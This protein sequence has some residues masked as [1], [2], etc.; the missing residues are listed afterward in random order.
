MP[1]DGDQRL[2][3]VGETVSE[4]QLPAELTVLPDVE[5]LVKAGEPPTVRAPGIVVTSEARAAANPSRL[6]EADVLVAAEIISPGTGT[7]DRRH[8]HR[9]HPQPS[10]HHPHP[11]RADHPV[12]NFTTQE[13]V[14]PVSAVSPGPQR[15]LRP[16]GANRS[17]GWLIGWAV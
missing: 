14:D 4:D 2:Q 12:N 11:G 3:N 13:A 10:R 6:E 16:G 1:C 15:R 5:V 8:R 7:T 17:R 9:D